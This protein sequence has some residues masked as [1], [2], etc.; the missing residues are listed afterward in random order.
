MGLYSMDST[1]GEAL[2]RMIEDVLLRFNLSISNL[3]G[4]TYDGAANMA[5]SYNGCQAIISRMQPLALYVH[6][7][8]HC[9]N[10]VAQSAAAECTDIMAAMTWLQEL[11]KFFGSSIK[12]R[13]LFAQ[14]A[15]TDAEGPWSAIKPL[16]PT[17]WLMRT[18]A[19]NSVVKQYG[20]VLESLEAAK[21]GQKDTRAASLVETCQKGSTLLLLQMALSVFGPLELLN[22]SL[23]SSSA[24]VDQILEAVETVK[25]DI[26]SSRTDESFHHLFEATAHSATELDL[27]LVVLPRQRKPPKRYTGPAAAHQHVSR[28]VLQGQVVLVSGYYSP[29]A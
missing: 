3:R 7:G 4:Q 17:R 29:A 1:T 23:Q 16:C 6:C 9:V 25:K 18:P 26:L 24:S 5:G 21:I 2:A 15:V 10:L 28:R 13:Q 20:A 22:K 11:G 12:F 8:A 27:E 14:V 19:I